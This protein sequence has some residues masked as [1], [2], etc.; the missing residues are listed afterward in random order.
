MYQN[1]A[2]YFSCNYVPNAGIYIVNQ[3]EL[4]VRMLGDKFH[5]EIIALDKVCFDDQT[6]V[7]PIRMLIPENCVRAISRTGRLYDLIFPQ[8]QNSRKVE[9]LF[10]C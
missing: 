5:K 8:Q 3:E 4:V 1:I 10:S 6:I 7:I 2:D 9:P